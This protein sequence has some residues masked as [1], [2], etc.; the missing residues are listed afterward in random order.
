MKRLMNAIVC[1]GLIFAGTKTLADEPVQ[2]GATPT[3]NHQMFKDCMAR[4]A[5]QNDGTSKADMKQACIK[6]VHTQK[7]DPGVANTPTD[8]PPNK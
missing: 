3:T 2:G 7:N 5:A 8:S 4:H 1:T 6:E